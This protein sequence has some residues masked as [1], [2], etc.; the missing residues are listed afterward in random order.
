MKKFLFLLDFLSTTKYMHSMTRKILLSIFMLSLFSALFSKQALSSDAL[1]RGP[2]GG[3]FPN[4][5]GNGTATAC[6]V[7]KVGNPKSAPPYCSNSSGNGALTGN[8]G[9]KVVQLAKSQIGRPYVWGGCHGDLKNTAPPKGCSDSYDCSGL[10]RWAWYWATDGGVNWLGTTTSWDE[11][12]GHPELAQRFTGD[13][14]K[15]LL[16]PGDLIYFGNPPY[17]TV[18]WEGPTGTCGATD[19]IIEAPETGQKVKENKL[20][21]HKNYVGFLRPV[22]K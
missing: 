10:T 4:N 7:V 16:Q 2:N 3:Y 22:V 9:E 19:C 13:S 8:I 5:S 14:S 6:A 15:N 1:P 11:V 12:S 20:S 21:N 18:I 17:H